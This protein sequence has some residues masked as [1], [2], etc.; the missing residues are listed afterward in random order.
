MAE[1]TIPAPGDTTTMLSRRR[2]LGLTGA[3]AAAAAGVTGFGVT[4]CAD[5]ASGPGSSAPRNTSATRITAPPPR[6]VLG[7]NIN[8]ASDW[9]NFAE[10]E[11]VQASWLRAF[12]PVPDA[13][14]GAVNTQRPISTLL[15]AAGRGYGTMLS[16]KF[17][18]FDQAVPTPGSAEMATAQRRVDAVLAA[19]MGTVDILAVG[20][21][22]FI[23]CRNRND[24]ALNVF[25]EAIAQRVIAYRDQHGGSGSKTRIYMGALNHLNEKSWR[26]TT[27]DRWMKFV[28]DTPA[29]AG[30]DMHPHLP[31]VA[32]G[33]AYL[34]YVLPRLRAD[35]TFLATEFS[36][37]LL[38][39]KHLGD[40]ISAEF[41]S[42]YH[43]PAGTLV[44]QVIQEAI[45]NPFPQQKWNDFLLMS[46]WFAN[47]RSFLSDQV[48]KFRGTGKLAAAAYGVT[49]DTAMVAHFGRGSTPWML[50]SLFC[51]Y[52][53]R[54]QPG[55]LPG[56]TTQ[57]VDEFRA[58]Q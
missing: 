52:T 12:F 8:G 55:G 40:K 7:A 17:P 16:L 48:G 3:F 21:E 50:N 22:P 57:W 43:L 1:P 58:L 20:N 38:Y 33:Q 42:H 23:E 49:E 11:A 30:T 19:V 27:T 47:N 37:V 36:L 15:D 18:Y 51:P 4:A 28:H 34:D 6:N 53:V 45:E 25:Y 46:P 13:D 32:A 9:S 10:L 26:T 14:K 2:A 29:V 54:S 5:V 24:P 31:D 44:W 56:Q 41:A 39:K 35:Q